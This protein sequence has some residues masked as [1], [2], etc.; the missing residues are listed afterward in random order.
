MKKKNS[1]FLFFN[2]P[3]YSKNDSTKFPASGAGN[4]SESKLISRVGS[5]RCTKAPFAFWI[6]CATSCAV[7]PSL[8]TLLPRYTNLSTSSILSSTSIN[9]SAL[10]VFT[11]LCFNCQSYLSRFF[12]QV[13][14]LCLHLSICF[15]QQAQ[16]ISK[17]QIF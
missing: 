15:R 17:V 3:F 10:F 4:I 6:L 2:I 7:L 11:L 8:V 9:G 13:S 14:K 12:C 16:V 1:K 5:E